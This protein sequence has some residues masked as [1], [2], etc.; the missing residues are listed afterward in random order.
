MSLDVQVFAGLPVRDLRPALEWYASLFGRPADEV[1]G[2]EAMWQMT[3]GTWLFV[4][5][6]GERAGGGLVTLGVTSLEPYLSRWRTAGLE[7]GS[8]ETYEN[9]V[10][11]VTILD[12]DGN[13]VS[14]ASAPPQ[15]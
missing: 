4:T 8:V 6:N 15:T 11:H 5:P 7:H 12:P 9:G 1:V 14:L 2:D 10:Q 13:S 3:D